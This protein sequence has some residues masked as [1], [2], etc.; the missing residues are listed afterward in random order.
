[1]DHFK[2]LG[3]ERESSSKEIKDAYFSLAQKWHPDINKS[4]E[5]TQRFKLISAAYDAIKDDE[6]RRK[7]LADHYGIDSNSVKDGGMKSRE[8]FRPSQDA[9]PFYNQTYSKNVNR[10]MYIFEALIS[11]KM[12]FIYLPTAALLYWSAK[13]SI[14]NSLNYIQTANF[15]NKNIATH[16]VGSS[17]SSTDGFA[18]DSALARAHLVSAWFNKRSNRWETPAP[19]DADFQKLDKDR[20]VKQVDRRRVA[21]HASSPHS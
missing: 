7:I 17:N 11:P 2:V 12:L 13:A 19:W 14:I 10:F 8:S 21:V 4:P 6:K 9:K 16:H 20:D 3:V 15:A 1:M 5:A 18:G